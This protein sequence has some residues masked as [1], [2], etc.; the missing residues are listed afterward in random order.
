MRGFIWFI[1]ET[2]L[3][4]LYLFIHF[5]GPSVGTGPILN[6]YV[7]RWKINLPTTEYRILVRMA[8]N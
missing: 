2:L 6:L 4:A 7:I 1:T 8:V 3:N 5:K